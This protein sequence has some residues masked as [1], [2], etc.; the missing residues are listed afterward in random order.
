MQQERDICSS[1][2]RSK[3]DPGSGL[4]QCEQPGSMR[5]AELTMGIGNWEHKTPRAPL[6]TVHGGWDVGRAHTDAPQ[7]L[8][9]QPSPS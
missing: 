2:P 4:D 8:R 3:K 9:T 7:H 5:A 1:N 6:Q